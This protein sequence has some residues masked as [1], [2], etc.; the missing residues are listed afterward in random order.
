MSTCI[1]DTAFMPVE[2]ICH[3]QMN[4]GWAVILYVYGTKRCFLDFLS[5][6]KAALNIFNIKEIIY[7]FYFGNNEKVFKKCR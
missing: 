6:L 7:C 2:I 3:S 4:S 5:E 1:K